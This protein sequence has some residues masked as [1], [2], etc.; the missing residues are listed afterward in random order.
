[1]KT[2]TVRFIIIAYGFSA[3]FTLGAISY[4]VWC[5]VFRA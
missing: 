2:F 4:L 5:Y 1:M 3:I